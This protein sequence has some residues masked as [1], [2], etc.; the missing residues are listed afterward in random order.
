MAEEFNTTPEFP[1]AK[2]SNKTMI[3]I[4]VVAVVVLCCCCAVVI[5]AWQFGDQ[6]LQALNL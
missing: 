5:G 3:I 1:V 2:K 4:I 6:I